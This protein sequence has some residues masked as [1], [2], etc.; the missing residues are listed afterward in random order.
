[1]RPGRG[2]G[3]NAV[4]RTRSGYVPECLLCSQGDFDTSSPGGAKCFPVATSRKEPTGNYLP[5]FLNKF[6]GCSALLRVS[7]CDTREAGSWSLPPRRA[8]LPGP[9]T[10][11]VPASSAAVTRGMGWRLP[12]CPLLRVRMGRAKGTKAKA[13]RRESP[14]PSRL[15]PCHP[16]A[17]VVTALDKPLSG[18]CGEAPT[19]DCLPGPLTVAAS[20]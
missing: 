2:P 16:G 15:V 4:R 9:L 1:M 17:V 5:I 3:V 18:C 8:Q 19:A 13:E 10:D 12:G 14:T 7:G 11:M 6:T 20:P